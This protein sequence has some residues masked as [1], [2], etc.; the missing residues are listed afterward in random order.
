M[1]PRL[2]RRRLLSVSRDIEFDLRSSMKNGHRETDKR[3][4]IE[5]SLGGRVQPLGWIKKCQKQIL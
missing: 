5:K 2:R 1:L 4:D 3:I